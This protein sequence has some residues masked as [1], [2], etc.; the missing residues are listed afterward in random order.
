MLSENTKQA[1]LQ[2]NSFATKGFP[3]GSLFLRKI[4]DEAKSELF[5]GV[6]SEEGKIDKNTERVFCEE[7]D[8]NG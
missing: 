8:K 3:K 1:K 5:S 2:T 6:K 4:L 7:N